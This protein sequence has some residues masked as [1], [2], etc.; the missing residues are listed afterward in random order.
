MGQFQVAACRGVDLHR[1]R[2]AFA[3]R[4]A[5]ERQFAFLGDLQIFDDRAERPQLGP[6]EGAEGVERA[7]A[8]KLFEPF[9]GPGAVEGGAAQR[10]DRGAHFRY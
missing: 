4:R 5:Q 3:D 1:L 6:G 7:D 9:L 10:R 8:V 2:G